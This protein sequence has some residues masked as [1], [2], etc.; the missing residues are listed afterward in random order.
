[1]AKTF[2]VAGGILAGVAVAAG[3][4]GA[5]LLQNKLTARQMETFEIGVRYQMFHSLALLLVGQLCL[6]FQSNALVLAGWAW[7]FGILLFS[8]SL[9]LL[10]C[11]NLRWF[12][13]V[14]PVGGTA[15]LIGWLLLV[16]AMWKEL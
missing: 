4:F 6:R 13:A 5:H 16:A 11:W 14:T 15:F 9:Y 12:G 10:S 1:M 2:L 3:A 8:G 7:I